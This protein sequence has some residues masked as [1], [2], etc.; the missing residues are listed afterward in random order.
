MGITFILDTCALLALSELVDKTL[1]PGTIQQIMVAD[2]L[3][4]SP[5]SLHEMGVKWKKGHLTL[6]ETPSVYWQ[7]SIARY[8]LTPIP[9]TAPVLARAYN[10]PDIHRDPFY[11]HF[12][13]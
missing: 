2:E 10:L 12:M 8:E 6:S 1:S 13:K 9:I 4:V 3:V 5:I 11:P 7:R